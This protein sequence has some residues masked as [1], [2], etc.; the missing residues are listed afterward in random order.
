[1]VL[2]VGA[3]GPEFFDLKSGVAG[4]LLHR[5]SLYRIRMA[6]VVPDVEDHG[7]RFGEFVRE[8]NRGQLCRFCRTRMEASAWLLEHDADGA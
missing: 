8:A 3:L 7:E 5:L 6:A 4:E 2:D 1:M